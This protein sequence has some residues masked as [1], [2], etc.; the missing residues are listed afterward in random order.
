MYGFAVILMTIFLVILLYF[1]TK[2]AMNSP[3]KISAQFALL[4]IS[5]YMLFEIRFLISRAMPRTYFTIS[6][7]TLFFTA[8][9]SISGI[10]A[11]VLGIL[12]NTA[13]LAIDFICFAF[14]LFLIY[15]ISSFI[16]D[17]AHIEETKNTEI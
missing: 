17:L 5:V 8:T 1:D 15:R 2:I 12:Q 10:V 13:Y 7:L 9:C 3:I 14:S 6:L 16:S 11:F 4:S